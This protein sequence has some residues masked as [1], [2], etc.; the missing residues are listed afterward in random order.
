VTPRKLSKLTGFF[1][2]HPRIN[3][4]DQ[5]KIEL[6]GK[7]TV[8]NNSFQEKSDERIEDISRDYA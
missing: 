2:T 7:A 4:A 8:R 1:E 3:S 5:V 6:M